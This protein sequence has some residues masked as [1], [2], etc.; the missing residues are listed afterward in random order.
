MPTLQASE[1]D[2]NNPIQ[3]CKKMQTS[4]L[5]YMKSGTIC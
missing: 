4:D 1:A 2:W 3:S 5:Q